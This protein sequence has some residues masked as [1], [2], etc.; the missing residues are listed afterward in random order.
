MNYACAPCET[1]GLLHAAHVTLHYVVLHCTCVSALH[2]LSLMDREQLRRHTPC[3]AGVCGVV[4]DNQG[5]GVRAPRATRP[6][7][8]GSFP[9]TRTSHWPPEHEKLFQLRPH[10][11]P[12]HPSLL[13]EAPKRKIYCTSTRTQVNAL[14]SKTC[15]THLRE[16]KSVMPV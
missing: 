13:H 5:V 9:G 7:G 12:R 16:I 10:E 6:R 11:I 3:Q 15:E 1:L 14:P 4:S 8:L 2:M